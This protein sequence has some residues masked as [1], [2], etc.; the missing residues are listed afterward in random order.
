MGRTE[1]QHTPLPP[2]IVAA[3][4]RR[5]LDEAAVYAGST[6][7]NP[8]VGCVLLD[9]AGRLLAAAAHR[10]A[11]EAHA[12][13]R[14]ITAAQDLGLASA[15]HTVVV[16]LEPCNHT[17]RTPPC[18]DAIAATPARHIVIGAVDPNPGVTGGGAA[19][20]AAAGF[21]V[22]SVADL[23]DPLAPALAADAARLIAPFAKRVTTGQP[24]ITIKQ[25][26]DETG[27]MIPPPGA[28]TFTSDASL[29]LAHSLR[30]R[31]D[32]ILTGSGTVLADDPAFTVRRVA[33]F[34]GKRRRLVLADRRHR[35]P[36]A[37]LEAARQRGFEV[38]V[39]DDLATSL[40]RLGADG[41]LEVLVEAGPTL[42]GYMLASGLWDEHVRI[43]RHGAAD[44]T[45]HVEIRHIAA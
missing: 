39:S 42:T 26:L 24:F 11:G 31:A 9:A 12:E 14:A 2:A 40:A 4:F 8:P 45:D 3:A 44:G 34:P 21:A 7:P 15:I 38:E 23:A 13:A 6:A 5:A 28:R 27:S 30:R 41:A 37:Y 16:T 43:T 20:L 32:A 33:D 36:A 10:R 22:T 29:T 25:A 18:T 19:R 17:G 35:V 1:T